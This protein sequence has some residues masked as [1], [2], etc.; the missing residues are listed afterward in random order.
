MS[1]ISEFEPRRR[2]IDVQEEGRRSRK[3]SRPWPVSAWFVAI[4]MIALNL[5]LGAFLVKSEYDRGSFRGLFGDADSSSGRT[6]A[7]TPSLKPPSPAPVVEAPRIESQP[8]VRPPQNPVPEQTSVP[9]TAAHDAVSPVRRSESISKREFSA[10]QLKAAPAPIKPKLTAP[11]ES[12]RLTATA[13]AMRQETVRRFSPEPQP[14]ATIAAPRTPVLTAPVS[15]PAPKPIVAPPPAVVASAPSPS[16]GVHSQ[17]EASKK[18][19]AT[20]ATGTAA[21]KPQPAL[22]TTTGQNQKPPVRVASVGLPAMDKGIIVPKTSVNSTSP[23]IEIVRRPPE[24]KVNVPNC[25]GDV[26]IPCP[27][28]K[29][30]PPG[31]APEGDRW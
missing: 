7:A 31:G 19:I 3:V 2:Q 14:Q 24:P 5:G 6:N 16:V 4:T 28:L 29:K 8:E 20:A 11:V 23:K 26:V 30:R 9:V 22:D 25:G 21:K 17:P 15:T 27:T 12:R 18:V 10:G 1:P 13:P